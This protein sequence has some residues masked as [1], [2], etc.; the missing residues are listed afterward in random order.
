MGIS[1]SQRWHQVSKHPT[2]QIFFFF[3]FFLEASSKTAARSGYRRSKMDHSHFIRGIKNRNTVR[4]PD[5]WSTKLKQKRKCRAANYAWREIYFISAVFLIDLFLPL[6]LL[7]PGTRGTLYSKS[8]SNRRQMWVPLF[9][10]WV[11][12]LWCFWVW[13]WV[14]PCI[15]LRYL[16]T[17]LFCFFAFCFFPP[18]LVISVWN[19]LWV[20]M[21][22]KCSSRWHLSQSPA[23]FSHLA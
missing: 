5:R 10:L 21:K 14:F 11:W 8:K 22:T 19:Y 4:K 2:V 13:M 3:F 12:P 7:P 23:L 9:D 16:S 15:T 18:P 6:S 1:V 20:W 17:F